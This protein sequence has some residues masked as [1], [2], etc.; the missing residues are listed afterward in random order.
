MKY[1]IIEHD[2]DWDDHGRF[3][4]WEILTEKELNKYKK[5]IEDNKEKFDNGFEY[6]YY[7]YDDVEVY[8]YNKFVSIFKSVKEINENTK[9]I[10]EEYTSASEW[11]M[12]KNIFEDDWNEQLEE[13]DTFDKD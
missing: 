10:I 8:N 3:T 4:G 7:F 5:I 12:L 13:F 1:F 9:N 2:I 11:S 6:K